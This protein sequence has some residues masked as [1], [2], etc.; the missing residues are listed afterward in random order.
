VWGQTF[1]VRF[2]VDPQGRVTDVEVEPQIP[3]RGYRKK[4]VD[5]MFRFRFKPAHLRDG[6]SVAGTTILTYTL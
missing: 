4:F 3:D 2:A 1:L 6:T 5:T